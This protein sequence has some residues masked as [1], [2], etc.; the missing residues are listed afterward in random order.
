MVVLSGLSTAG[1]LP[2]AFLRLASIPE[3]PQL[4]ERS[5]GRGV[6]RDPLQRQV[7]HAPVPDFERARFP[8][9]A[10]VLRFCSGLVTY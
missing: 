6:E 10:R 8:P 7:E 3:R 5:A 9:R 4:R 2:L 1:S